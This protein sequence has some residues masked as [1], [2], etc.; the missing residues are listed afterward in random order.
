M[1]PYKVDRRPGAQSASAPRKYRLL[2]HR[3]AFD[4]VRSVHHNKRRISK[5]QYG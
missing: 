5:N 2:P 3:A 4:V 1:K